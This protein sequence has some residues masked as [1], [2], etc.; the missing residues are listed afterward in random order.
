MGWPARTHI[1]LECRTL[2]V[3]TCPGGH[4][5]V[6]LLRERGG[7]DQL[8]DDVWGPASLRP[9][10]LTGAAVAPP[11]SNSRWSGWD[12]FGIFELDW[13]GLILIAGALFWFAG[14]AIVRLF[15]KRAALATAQGARRSGASLLRTGQVGT[16]ALTNVE[17]IFDRP[18]VAFGTQL[19]CNGNV[20][21]RDGSTIGFDVVLDGG[22]R[23]HVPA[24]LCAIDMTD[25]KALH[26]LDNYLADVDPRRAFEPGVDPFHHDD[27]RVMTIAPGDR[28]EILGELEPI[29]ATVSGG[30]RDAAASQLV[31]RGGV[32]L[33][34]VS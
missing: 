12:L 23:V 22:Q 18:A 9:A 2:C 11:A 7:R 4:K 1:C 14:A 33:R 32:R 5:R 24:G 27:A 34:R 31:P 20:M 30:Y 19:S 3:K 29:A 13:F 10:L 17:S 21:L 16:V 26:G 15:R 28:V 25:A 6:V 8:V